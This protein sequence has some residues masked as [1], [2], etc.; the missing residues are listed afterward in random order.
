MSEFLMVVPPDWEQCTQAM[1]D[2]AIAVQGNIE[3]VQA[4]IDSADFDGLGNA[5]DENRFPTPERIVDALIVQGQVFIKVV[6]A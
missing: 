4:Y 2:N 6:P 3:G 5:L 1:V